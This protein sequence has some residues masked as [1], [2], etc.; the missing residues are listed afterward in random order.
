MKR[1]KGRLLSQAVALAM[2]VV[3]LVPVQAVAHDYGPDAD[4]LWSTAKL[5]PNLYFYQDSTA[6]K[7]WH[8]KAVS[9]YISYR[10]WGPPY[11][12]GRW[13]R[14]RVR[15]DAGSGDRWTTNECVTNKGP[16]PKG[17]Y[18]L[19]HYNKTW[20]NSTVRGWVWYMGDKLCENGSVTRTELFIHSQGVSATADHRTQ[21]C[22]EIGQ[23]SRLRLSSYY[24]YSYDSA[25]GKLT[26][27][28]R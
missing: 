20:G 5:R 11:Y 2:L 7:D 3:G 14:R 1:R 26:V 16:A 9:A 17:V 18:N 4:T 12:D 15:A 24:R 25:N 13:E 6:P 27:R 8:D 23:G 21:G 22:V 19:D 28:E 10:N